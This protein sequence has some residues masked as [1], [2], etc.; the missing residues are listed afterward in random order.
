MDRRRATGWASRPR[1]YQFRTRPREN[2]ALRPQP[3]A[4]AGWPGWRLRQPACSRRLPRRPSP[5][6]ARLVW[7]L[8]LLPVS[9]P[10]RSLGR[11]L[12]NWLENRS[13]RRSARQPLRGASWDWRRETPTGKRRESLRERPTA[14]RRATRRPKKTRGK[15]RRE[16]L[17]ASSLLL[18]SAL[19]SSLLARSDPGHRRPHRR[20]AASGPVQTAGTV[21]ST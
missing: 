18:S 14:T 4:G 1:Q 12:E 6:V 15:F 5:L 2:Q 17:P 13:A 3:F 16:T 9:L 8:V 20:P 21:R 11:R 7:P 19:T 10:R